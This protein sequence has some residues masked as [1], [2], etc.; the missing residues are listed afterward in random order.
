MEA[1]A[2]EDAMF[3][4]LFDKLSSRRRQIVEEFTQCQGGTS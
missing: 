2:D 4:P 1:L 3:Q